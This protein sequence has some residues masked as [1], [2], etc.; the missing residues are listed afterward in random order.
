MGTSLVSSLTKELL[1]RDIIPFDS[2]SVTNIG[3]QLVAA[4]SGYIP[5]W[6]D[7]Y[8]TVLDGSSSYQEILYDLVAKFLVNK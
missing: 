3:S 2:T 8:G 6:V 5:A 7:T 1:K 4:R